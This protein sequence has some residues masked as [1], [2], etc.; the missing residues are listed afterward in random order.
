[1]NTTKRTI[2]SP[3]GQK[4]LETLRQAVKKTLEKKRRLGQYAVIWKDGKPVITGEEASEQ[5]LAPP[6]PFA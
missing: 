2:P 4:R 1:M 5:T 3:E 6:T